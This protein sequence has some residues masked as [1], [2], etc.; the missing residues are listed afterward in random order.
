[1]NVDRQSAAVTYGNFESGHEFFF[2]APRVFK[3][4]KLTSYGGNVSF[5]VRY[6]GSNPGE[7]P[8]N[9]ELILSGGAG[10][11]MVYTNRA[12]LAAFE[13]HSFVV[14]L[15]E[16]RTTRAIFFFGYT[17]TNNIRTRMLE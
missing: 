7:R 9:L 6:E 1:M 17:H 15:V 10:L 5:S 4:N 13:D 3:G 16:V 2:E 11:K 8:K 14:P 12:M